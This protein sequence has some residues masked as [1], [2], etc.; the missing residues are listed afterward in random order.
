MEHSFWHERWADGR[1]G[2]HEGTPNT[3]LTTHFATLGMKAGQRVFVPLCG[4]ST[5]LIWLRAQGL[6]VIGA[7]LDRSAV[8]AFFAD[9]EIQP[10]VVKTGAH[11]TFSADGITLFVGDIFKL[12][13]A[14]IGHIDAVYDRAA[15]VALPDGM[16]QRYAAHLKT[17]TTC[18]PQLLIT[19]DYDQ[20]LMNGPPFSVPREMVNTLYSKD[21]SL[22][23]LQSREITG[24]LTKRGARGSEVASLLRPKGPRP[25][26]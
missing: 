17:I 18:A 16:R 9:N 6:S 13:A 5:D 19:F 21:F 26:S 15:L 11:E 3:L 23:E 1:I 10:D 20:S 25:A 14:D 7:E 12:S 8:A 24:D 2:F 4:K 22:E